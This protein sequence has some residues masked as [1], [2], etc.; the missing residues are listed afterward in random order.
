MEYKGVSKNANKYILTIYILIAIAINFLIIL[1]CIVIETLFDFK[2]M[3]VINLL[4]ISFTI[5]AYMWAFLVSSSIASRYKYCVT[6]NKVE[7]IKGA[8]II[9]RKIML[10]NKVYKI[11]I[12][13]GVIG[14]IFKVVSIKFHSGGG[15]IKINY[16]DYN[17]AERINEVVKKGMYNSYGK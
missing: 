2:Y 13:R 16:I 3:I 12:T 8:M 1:S 5:F 4:A 15:S 17:E 6:K 10:V 11:E 9:S 7:V 14:R